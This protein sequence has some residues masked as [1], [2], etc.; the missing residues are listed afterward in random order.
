MTDAAVSFHDLEDAG[1]L[2]ARVDESTFDRRTIYAA[3]FTFIDRA[4][5]RLDRKE[6]GRIDVVLREKSSGSLPADARQE[7]EAALYAARLQ[8]ASSASSGAWADSILLSA[9]GSPENLTPSPPLPE[10]RGGTSSALP[11]VEPEDLAA[12]DDPLGIA[13]SWEEKH[14]KPK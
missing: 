12:F 7:L 14:R 11:A 1:G 4:W 8:H 10:G 6:P 2:L 5:V 9:L 13:Q 3:A